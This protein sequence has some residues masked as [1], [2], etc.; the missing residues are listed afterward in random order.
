VGLLI[1]LI[2]NF[3]LLLYWYSSLWGGRVPIVLLVF[4]HDHRV[5][6]LFFILFT[7]PTPKYLIIV[8]VSI[9]VLLLLL[10]TFTSFIFFFLLTFYILINNGI[11]ILLLNLRESRLFEWIL[12][13]LRRTFGTLGAFL[14]SQLGKVLRIGVNYCYRIFRR[15][16]T[17]Y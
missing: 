3:N 2:F 17:H 7:N 4:F 6:V 5:T 16:K 13:F 14:I 8:L 11:F 12:L 1:I 9:F 10:L 15:T